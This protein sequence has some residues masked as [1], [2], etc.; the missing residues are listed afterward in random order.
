MKN[1]KQ[2]ILAAGFAT[3]LAFVAH[4]SASDVVASP[5]VQQM[6]NDMTPRPIVHVQAPA[7]TYMRPGIEVTAASPRARQMMAD[8]KVV[9]SGAAASEVASAVY[10]PVGTDGLTASPKVRS[11]LDERSTPV[12]I[13]P[14]K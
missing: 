13:A 12:T 6:L 4:A 10:T 8:R 7:I 5:K 2:M 9:V 3:T 14:L 11:Q 1:S